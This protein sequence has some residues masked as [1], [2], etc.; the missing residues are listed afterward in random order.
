MEYLLFP[1]VEYFPIYQIF[2]N[3]AKLWI[4]IYFPKL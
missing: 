4:I 1:K 2:A 3:I